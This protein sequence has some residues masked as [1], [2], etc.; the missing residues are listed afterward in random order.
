[1]IASLLEHGDDTAGVHMTGSSIWMLIS[2]IAFSIF[3]LSF[4]W[5]LLRPYRRS[6]RHAHD[7]IGDDELERVLR[8]T[9]S[10]KP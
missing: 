7:E 3:L 2:M 8:D 10:R 6:E 9:R 1:M 4:A 5:T